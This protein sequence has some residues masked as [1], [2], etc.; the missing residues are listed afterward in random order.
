MKKLAILMSLVFILGISE[1]RA[2]I[3]KGL[4]KKIEKKIEDRLDRKADK[5]V[6]KV[7]DKADHAT[8]K[9]LD[10]ILNKSSDKADGSQ[11]DK[12]VPNINTQQGETQPPAINTSTLS[13]GLVVMSGS[14]CTDFI[15]FKTGAMMEFETKD[16]KGKSLNKSR[17]EISKVH[18]EGA[19]TVAE[20]IASDGEGNSFMMQF[21]CAGD[22]MYMDFGSLIKQAMQQAG[23]EGADNA[24]IQRAMDNTEIGF[25]DGFM[26]FPKSMYPGQ[27]LHDVSVS[28]NS[29]PTPQ[30][31]IE[32]VSTL[33][34]RKVVAKETVTT[35]AGSFDCM[36]ISGVRK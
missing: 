22:K 12:E 18:N 23:Q 2:Q 25:S 9:P 8:D 21:K 32:M 31:S 7:L 27:M 29:S 13:E 3:L 6:D 15:W 26:D 30:L 35:E 20:A 17:T 34:D 11:A 19:L 5:S 4:G 33:T 16:S 1:S 36:K 24:S 10:N 28:I 14:S